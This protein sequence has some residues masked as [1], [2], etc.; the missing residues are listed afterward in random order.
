MTDMTTAPRSTTAKKALPLIGG[1]AFAVASVLLLTPG[2]HAAEA[3]SG[4]GDFNLGSGY[5]KG[6]FSQDSQLL[7]CG[8]KGTQ[9]PSAP[10][11]ASGM[12]DAAWIN[13]HYSSAWGGTPQLTDDLVAGL[14]R[15]YHENLGTSAQPDAALEYATHA[16]MYPGEW[17]DL[18]GAQH[19]NLQEM[20]ATDLALPE[21]NA[22]GDIAAVQDYVTKFLDVIT[23]T[24]ASVP[25][26]GE[27]VVTF[28]AGA[29]QFTK[30]VTVEAT[31]GATG[32]LSLT[33]AVFDDTGEATRDVTAGDVFTVRV[34]APAGVESTVEVTGA[35]DM[36]VGAAGYSSQLATWLPES[37]V[38]QQASL[39]LG[40]VVEQ[41]A[42]EIS[43]STKAT[44]TVPKK[45]KPKENKPVAL[46]KTGEGDH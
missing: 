35:A 36:T 37:G 1:V 40:P 15:V 45:D 4:L 6:S 33:N 32:T 7:I 38:N 19:A 13:S 25:I 26:D 31:D 22:G 42:F 46:V 5:Y 39:G 20:I 16:V 41:V 28:A 24:T 43:G 27:G 23:T 34:T 30:T 21:V 2:A 17:R 11:V 10:L 29:D 14:N 18:N 9:V 8:E 12:Q 44:I 3:G